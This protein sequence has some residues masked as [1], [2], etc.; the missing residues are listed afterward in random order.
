MQRC[1][2]AMTFY[3][4]SPVGGLNELKPFLSEHGNPY[5]YFTTNPLV[6]LL[7]AVKPVPKPFSFYPYGFDEKGTVVYSDYYEDAFYNL[8]KNRVGYLYECDH[9]KGLEKPTKI[10]DVYTSTRPIKVD[11]MTK[12]PDLYVFYKQQEE[13]GLF[14]I[15]KNSEIQDKTM[16]FVFEELRKEIENNSL[17]HNP[18]HAMSIFIKEHFPAVWESVKN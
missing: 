7:Y 1:G 10:K 3:H 8:Y 9:L 16:C 5:V 11:R 17:K 14:R 6:A 18:Q 4:G 13:K 2:E 12:I 15:E